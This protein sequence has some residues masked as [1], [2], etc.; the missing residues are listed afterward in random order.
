MA[1]PR[2][3]PRIEHRFLRVVCGLP[4]GLNRAIFGAPARIDGQLLAAEMQAL[5]RLATLARDES[6]SSAGKLSPESARARLRANAAAAA[7]PKRSLP[8]VSGLAIPGPEGMIPARFYEPPGIGL[9]NRPLIV[10]FHGGGWTIGD[11]DTCDSVCRFLATNVPATVLSVGYRLAPEHPFPAAFVDA[12]A[13]FHWAANDNSRLG[14]DPSR[15][16]VAGDSAGGNLA[17]AVSL[18]CRNENGPKPAMQALLYPVTD[19]VGGQQSRDTFAEGFLLTRADMDWFEHHYLPV[20]VDRSD[21]RVSVLRGA[22]LAGLAPAY[23]ATAGFDP[24]RDEGE[25]YAT[26]MREAGVRVALRRHPELIHGF[27]NMTAI[28]P[29]SNAAMHELAGAVR[30]GLV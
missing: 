20:A 21:P 30:V 25:A 14:V 4:D 15:I 28:S 3:P 18:Y 7:G 24:L 10:Y 2:L 17:A 23:V 5:V 26:R 27:A 11:L 22:D 12:C 1:P 19:A 29:A 6:A 9:E 16:A 13:A 8:A